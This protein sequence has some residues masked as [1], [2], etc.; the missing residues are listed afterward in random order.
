VIKAPSKSLFDFSSLYLCQF[1]GTATPDAQFLFTNLEHLRII[2]ETELP[3]KD[4]SE[5]LKG[6]ESF[7]Q[8]NNKIENIEI[9]VQREKDAKLDVLANHRIQTLRS[10]KNKFGS[11]DFD[12]LKDKFN[13]LTTFGLDECSLNRLKAVD[14]DFLR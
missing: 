5:I 14:F 4:L 11:K 12:K 1:A 8:N 7:N 13:F 9:Q 2:L 6:Y 3:I 10:W